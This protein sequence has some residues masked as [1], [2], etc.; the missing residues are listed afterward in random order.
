MGT[1][2]GHG[3]IWEELTGELEKQQTFMEML[4]RSL[5]GDY[6]A[7]GGEIYCARGCSGCC[8]LVVNCTLTEAV[9]VAAT[10]DERQFSRI[11]AYV[12]RLRE[13]LAGVVELK[14]YLHLHRRSSGGCPLLEGD[15]SCGVYGAR[16][17]SCRALLAT[18][19]SRWCGA[20]FAELTQAEKQV[21][22]ESLDREAVAFPMHY[23]A[24]S[25][26]AGTGLEHQA[27]RRMGEVLGFSIYGNMPV[28]VHLVKHHDL[29]RVALAGRSAVAALL[30][31]KGLDNPLLLQLTE[32]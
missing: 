15:G 19:E 6:R 29:A 32:T 12:V 16:P 9:T 24:A 31:E 8:T 26:D 4:T 18:M 23:L 17:L 28:L 13:L 5:A 2:I 30:A 25:R 11:D 21:F 27:S 3:R 10:L 20:D 7:K 14:E 22:V 1:D